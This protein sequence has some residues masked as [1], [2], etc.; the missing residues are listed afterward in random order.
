MDALMINAL[1]AICICLFFLLQGALHYREIKDEGTFFLYNRRLPNGEYAYSFAAAS[2][3]LATVLFFFVTFGVVHGIYV[4]FAP[5][6][7]F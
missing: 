2:T 6:T 3:S 7:Y 5:I 1:V 4:L